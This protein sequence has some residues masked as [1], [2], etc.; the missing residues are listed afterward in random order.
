[1]TATVAENARLL[2]VLA[3]RD[4]ED[5]RQIATPE[6]AVSYRDELGASDLAGL[7]IGLVHEGFGLPSSE[8]MVDAAV[9]AAA[10]SLTRLGA[11]V[12]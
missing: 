4:G 11:E 7:K 2:E 12:I 5:S 8:P 6:A 10:D 1:M 9:R 3:G